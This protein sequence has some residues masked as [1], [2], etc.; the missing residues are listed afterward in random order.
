V[1]SGLY[2]GQGIIR[3]ANGSEAD[4]TAFPNASAPTFVR[5]AVLARLAGEQVIFDS[6]QRDVTEAVATVYHSIGARVALHGPYLGLEVPCGF[7]AEE[8]DRKELRLQLAD[9]AAGWAR[10]SFGSN[11][12]KAV[13]NIFQ[14]VFYN[15]KRLTLERAARLDADTAF[16]RRLS[17]STLAGTT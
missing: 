16:H 4:E 13:F 14:A 12:A 11:G 7:V 10:D 3:V 9:V 2:T 1:L 17:H 5:Q 6:G 8:D 15:G